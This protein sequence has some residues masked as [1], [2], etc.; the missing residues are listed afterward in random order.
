[1]PICTLVAARDI[2]TVMAAGVGVPPPPPVLE[3]V[4][5][6]PENSEIVRNA[7]TTVERDTKPVRNRF[8]IDS[9]KITD[10]F[11]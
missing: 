10:L 3:V 7:T 11:F 4:P 5:A 2:A 8:T 9:P 1:M 6:Q